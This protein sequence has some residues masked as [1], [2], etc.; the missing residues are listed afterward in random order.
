MTEADDA[1]DDRVVAQLRESLSGEMRAHVLDTFEASLVRCTLEVQDAVRRRN[2]GKLRR[3]AHLL[4][5]SSACLGAKQLVM[6]CEALEELGRGDGSEPASS[7][8][9]RLEAAGGVA[10]S[11]LRARLVDTDDPTATYASGPGAR[12]RLYDARATSAYGA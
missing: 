8:V 5:G 9:H 3:V 10:R 7:L 6:V 2:H 4:K 12:P 1:L 11:A